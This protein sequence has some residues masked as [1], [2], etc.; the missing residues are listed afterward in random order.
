MKT[1]GRCKTERNLHYCSN[2]YSAWLW[3]TEVY[4]ELVHF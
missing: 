1:G 3:S 2:L 4:V